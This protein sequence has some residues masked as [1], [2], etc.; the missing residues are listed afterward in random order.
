[1]LVSVTLEANSLNHHYSINLQ[2]VVLLNFL[3]FSFFDFLTFITY[4]SGLLGYWLEARFYMLIG[5]NKQSVRTF[6]RVCISH[7]DYAL[8]YACLSESFLTLC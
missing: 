3:L 8:K 1:M 6:D 2:K 4:Y 5:E 7:V